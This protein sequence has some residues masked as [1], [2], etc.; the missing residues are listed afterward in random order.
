MKLSIK[1]GSLC[2]PLSS[3]CRGPFGLQGPLHLVPG[4]MLI[5]H[6]CCVATWLTKNLNSW[7]EKI[8][9]NVSDPKV[10]STKLSALANSSKVW[11]NNKY[12]LAS[13]G[14]QFMDTQTHRQTPLLF[15]KTY[16]YSGNIVREQIDK[17]VFFYLN[18]IHYYIWTSLDKFG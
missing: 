18:I 11:C 14:D 6:E 8:L 7:F 10:I 13:V 4:H 16:I 9:E 3:S 17:F 5:I 1:F 12:Y 2:T 15:S